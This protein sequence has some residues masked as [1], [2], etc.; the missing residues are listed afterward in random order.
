MKSIT[1]VAIVA[2][3]LATGTESRAESAQDILETA[4]AAQVDRWEGLDSYMVEQSEMGRSA[5]RYF[6]RT[7]VADSAGTKRTMFLSA[8]D[9]GL[10]RGC[11]N[12]TSASN[13]QAGKGDMSAEYMTWF[14][15]T[16]TLVGEESIDG[17]TAYQLYSDEIDQ[18]QGLSTEE[19][20][21]TSM[22]MWLSKDDYLPL[23]MRMEGS[24]NA[25]GQ[26]R[27]VTIEMLASDFRKVPGSRLVEPFR[28]VVSIS[29]I[30]AGIG[31]AEVA[32]ARKAM[33]EF[34]EQLASM[35]ESQREMMKSMMGPQLERMRSLAQSG[36]I[37]SEILVKS[38]TP[39]PE[40]FGERIAACDSG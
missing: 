7:S 29:G 34:E 27:P 16:A 13:T 1:L 38:I 33:A 21:I 35:P 36:S 39:N 15:E 18:D 3:L 14:M 17:R 19:V 22:T 32:E 30:T 28:R 40:A 24:A 25:E 26:S 23:K 20:S 6:V 5:K 12:P 11:V 8:P 10:E 2:A 4:W 9:A 31:D 37:D